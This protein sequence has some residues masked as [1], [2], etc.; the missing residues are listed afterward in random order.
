[1][2]KVSALK[3]KKPPSQ[4][5]SIFSK[6]LSGLRRCRFGFLRLGRDFFAL[7]ITLAP[8][9]LDGFIVLLAHSSL[10]S[11]GIPISCEIL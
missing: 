3:T 2:K 1:M 9:L 5:A 11:V 6:K 10:H 7:E 4:V 8:F